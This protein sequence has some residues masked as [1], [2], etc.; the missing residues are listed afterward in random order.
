MSDLKIKLCKPDRT[1]IYN[2]TNVINPI[3]TQ[4][5]SGI[6]TLDFD[7]PYY[8]SSSTGE[9]VKNPVIPLIK[10]LYL[11]FYNGE[12]FIIDFPSKVS[13]EKSDTLKIKSYGLA[14]QLN[15]KRLRNFATG[16]PTLPVKNL[17]DTTNLVL[18]NSGWTIGNV[19]V[20]LNL[21]YRAINIPDATLLD[22]I[23]NICKT[24][25]CV[26]KYNTL[27]RTIDFVDYRTDGIFQGLVISQNRYLKNIQCE[28][29]NDLVTK[30]HVYGVD[31]LSINSVN[32]NG[33]NYITDYT[34]VKNT[35]Y[36]SVDMI[37]HL[38]TFENALESQSNVLQGYLVTKKEYQAILA[39]KQNELDLI[40]NEETYGV[41]NI[42]LRIDIAIANSESISALQT[43]LSARQVL[44]D[45]KNIQ[46][47]N[48]N[49]L[50]LGV[51][52]QISTL[53]S[54][55]DIANYLTQTEIGLLNDLTLES[56]YIDST[57]TSKGNTVEVLE[58][59]LTEAQKQLA[60][61]STP[62]FSATVDL[63]DFLSCEETSYDKDKLKIGD[64]IKVR[65]PDLDIFIDAKIVEIEQNFDNFGLN[66]SIANEKD[67]KNGF[68]NAQ[69][70]LK[71]VSSL[72]GTVSV[73]LN[74]WNN[75]GAAGGIISEYIN[76]AIDTT[77]QSILGGVDDS[78]QI[79]NRG[80]TIL[81]PTDPQYIQRFTAGAWGISSDGGETF[82]VGA[83]KGNLHAE[84]ISGN[85]IVGNTGKFNALQLYTGDILTGEIGKYLDDD[86]ITEN[87]G[88]QITNTAKKVRTTLDASEG[89]K[90]Q[91][92]TDLG[93]SWKN[94]LS[95]DASGN[96]IFTG[97]LFIG[98]TGT[99]EDCNFGVTTAGKLIGVA[100]DNGA[101]SVDADGNVI[102][103]G[104][105]ILGGSITWNVHDPSIPTTASDIGALP[106]STYIPTLPSYIQS[107]KITGTSVESCTIIGGSIT[108]ETTIDV[109]TDA[110][111]GKWLY[112]NGASFGGGIGW[113]DNYGTLVAQIYYDP[114]A[115]AIHIPDLYT[116]DIVAKFA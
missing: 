73:N 103:N 18:S 47:N 40:L 108:S 26:P 20:N 85:L 112:L 106:D 63:V 12:Y 109:G 66:I 35:D 6:D 44:A 16:I 91:N 54:S 30:L 33:Q 96:G 17:A 76:N 61:L 24:W 15:H 77:K 53:Q 48:T 97:S 4:Q 52:I 82:K 38:D 81:D 36:M 19:D 56:S 51:D 8:I 46:I 95:F 37:T 104:N 110:D 114:I 42:N 7:I 94:V 72:N 65:H 11:L 29:A 32:A 59:L 98:G 86:G 3:H 116:G 23:N 58:E 57:I 64:M 105:L 100:T 80:I 107:T 78:V 39:V 115:D 13:D 10:Q 88:I 50:I 31:D 84:V 14:Y 60:M 111:I 75:G 2:L 83:S 101:F 28:K 1:T 34:F 62:S 102:M 45:S 41:N 67:L 89:F 27:D 25:D 49:D 71:S 21:L 113:K 5:Y 9:Q 92:S 93:T 90:I 74:T 70:L 69:S 22:S 68:T 43:E 79:N 55:L 87:T 99:A